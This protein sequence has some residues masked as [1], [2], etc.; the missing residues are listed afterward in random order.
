MVSTYDGIIL[1]KLKIY[2]ILMLATTRINLKICKMPDANFFVIQF[3]WLSRKDKIIR[4][5]N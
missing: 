5:E 2:R 3:I 1:S 4:E